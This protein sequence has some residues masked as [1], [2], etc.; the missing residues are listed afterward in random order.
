[1]VGMQDQKVVLVINDAP[2]TGIK[3]S[4]DMNVCFWSDW[5]LDPRASKMNK[6]H[7]LYLLN[8]EKQD[9]YLD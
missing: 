9:L 5:G 2:S 8:L 4:D 7:S 1:M 6:F 3:D